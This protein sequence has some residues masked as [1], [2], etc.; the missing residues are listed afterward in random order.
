MA[1]KFIALIIIFFALPSE[2]F[3]SIAMETQ[4]KAE[5][6][7]IW[8]GGAQ[9]PGP[10]ELYIRGEERIQFKNGTKVPL[11]NQV[12]YLGCFLNHKGD[13]IKEVRKRMAECMG[14]FNKLEIYWK[15]G[16]DTVKQQIIVWDAVIR[17]K[18][19]YGLESVQINDQLKQQLNA[20][21][22]KGLR[23]ILGIMTTYGQLVAGQPLTNT[24]EL[25]YQKANEQANLIDDQPTKKTK[26][27]LPIDQIYEY[28]R[29]REILRMIKNRH[30][31]DDM[32]NDITFEP[33]TLKL[34]EHDKKRV[35][36]PRNNWW[37]EGKRKLWEW[38]KD[39]KLIPDTTNKPR[40]DEN[41]QTHVQILCKLADKYN[42]KGEDLEENEQALEERINK[43]KKLQSGEWEELQRP[44]RENKGKRRSIAKILH[45]TNRTRKR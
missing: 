32:N 26:V 37:I 33:S 27:I 17:A 42:E 18:L 4:R 9:V 11:H 13:P 19:L 41:N 3:G 15:K 1:F 29:R 34:I 5:E 6:K 23:K 39:M 30:L 2:I 24:V 22:Q 16:K 8:E 40:M 14:T 28:R 45:V 35:G 12:K 21:Q 43:R 7:F 31:K 36:G 38:N 25:V 44:Q 20:F 10:G